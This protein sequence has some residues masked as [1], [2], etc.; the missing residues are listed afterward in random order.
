M[1]DVDIPP[2]RLVRSVFFSWISRVGIGNEETTSVTIAMWTWSDMC[3]VD[4]E[5]GREYFFATEYA[6]V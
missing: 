3:S 5:A 1:A 4:L 2:G 6:K